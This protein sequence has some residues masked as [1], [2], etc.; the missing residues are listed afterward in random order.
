MYSYAGCKTDTPCFTACPAMA[1]PSRAPVPPWLS[2]LSKTKVMVSSSTG[3]RSLRCTSR[4]LSAASVMLCVLMLRLVAQAWGMAVFAWHPIMM[5]CAVFVF[6]TQ[7][8]LVYAEPSIQRPALREGHRLQMVLAAACFALGLLAITRN[9][10]RL[11]RSLWPHTV[12]ALVGALALVG[13][14]VQVVSGWRKLA[15]LRRSAS[16]KTMRWHGAIG[17]ATF[18]ACV[19]ACAVL[20]GERTLLLAVGRIW[21]DRSARRRRHALCARSMHARS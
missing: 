2:H 3:P 17:A 1:T 7:G 19:L 16:Q 13:V 15:L 8:M 5:T 4:A 9:K 10:V 6:G 21:I 20:G 11:G 12:H 18:D 14:G